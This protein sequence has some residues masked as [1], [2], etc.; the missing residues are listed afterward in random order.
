MYG[1]RTHGMQEE[2]LNTEW[3]KQFQTSEELTISITTYM[4]KV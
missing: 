1:L 3:E 2:G 4:Q